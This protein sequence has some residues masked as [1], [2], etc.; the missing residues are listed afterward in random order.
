MP[1]SLP[2]LPSPVSLRRLLPGASFVGCGELIVNDATD[3]SRLVTEDSVFAAIQGTKFDGRDF[4]ADAVANGCSAVMTDRPLPH[5]SAPQC[6]VRDVRAA[7]AKVCNA[8][9]GNPTSRLQIAGVTGTNGKTTTAW[10][11]RSILDASSRHCGLLG[12]IEYSDGNV[13]SPASLTTPGPRSVFQWFRRMVE[14]GCRHAAIELSSHALSQGRIAGTPLAAAIITN[15]TQDHF[16]Y[17]SDFEMYLAA[18]SKVLGYV[19]KDGIVA[20]NLDDPGSA[21]LV[22][23]ATA[24][25]HQVATFSIRQDATVRGDILEEGLTGT[26]FRLSAI[27][28]TGTTLT[29]AGTEI[30]IVLP[31][32]HNVLNS[33][34]AAAAAFHMGATFDDV[35]TGLE[36]LACVPGRLEPID[37]GQSFPVFVDYA[38]TDDALRRVVDSLKSLTNGR[39]LCVFGAGGDRDRAKRPL[40]GEAASH[41]DFAI[42]TSDNPRTEEPLGIIEEVVAGFP[43][44]FAS[45]H[46]ESDRR[47]AIEFALAEAQPGDCVLIAGKGHES[48]QIVGTD[49]LPFDDRSVAREL[50]ARRTS[51]LEARHAAATTAE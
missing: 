37:C 23:Q 15:V 6:I 34:G 16:D 28:F 47:R 21:Q 48:E 25:G 46:V 44:G 50:L 29:E 10:M 17:H 14:N 4:A 43:H 9:T 32:R 45:F 19:V 36:E 8:V 7:Y 41:A 24:E 51:A 26:R 30:S 38:H 31:G 20:I 1:Q 40:L 2:D 33:L 39:V 12:T 11:L 27:A 49:R 5:V 42:V 13:A 3:D 22:E 35:R 18:K